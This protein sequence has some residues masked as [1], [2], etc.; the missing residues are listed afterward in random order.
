MSRLF[1]LSPA[2]LQGERGRRVL[3]GIGGAPFADRLR[4][5]ESVPLG[6][7]YQFIS[8]LYYRGKRS[9]ARRFAT[10]AEGGEAV[11]VVTP[12]R[13][14]VPDAEPVRLDDLRSFAG[15]DIDPSNRAYRRALEKSLRILD[16]AVEASGEVVLL[17]SIASA[18]YLEP[19]A[20]VFGT[21]LLV[22][23]DFA[24]R[25]DMSRGGLLLRAVD[26]G[27][28]LAYVPASASA[29]HGPRPPKLAPS[30]TRKPT[31]AGR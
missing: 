7:V 9:Y 29:R 27:V 18:K 26:A 10:R 21:R 4:R 16:S 5:D 1:V 22:P 23:R 17:G 6:D 15:V 20:E 19:L 3:A 30:P 11:F 28:E 31:R 25:G 2:S 24:G 8:S 12:T 14:V 13:G